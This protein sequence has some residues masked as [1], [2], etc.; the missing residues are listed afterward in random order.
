MWASKLL[1]LF[2]IKNHRER[3]KF[4]SIICV[5]RKCEY[6]LSNFSVECKT[7]LTFH[8]IWSEI[9]TSQEITG[10]NTLQPQGKI[11]TFLMWFMISF[12]NFHYITIQLKYF[13]VV[14]SR[15]VILTQIKL[16]ENY[17]DIKNM[18]ISNPPQFF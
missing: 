4:E 12:L 8:C 18:K 5:S 1:N 11:L 9:Y 15:L 14:H 6:I 7:F 2:N 16:R 17:S 3:H 13:L 10:V